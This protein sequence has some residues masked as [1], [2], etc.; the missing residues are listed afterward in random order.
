[1]T[2]HNSKRIALI[3]PGAMGSALAARLAEAGHDVLTSLAGRSAASHARA[4]AAGMA[5]ATDA[6]LAECDMILSVVPPAEADALVER[7]VPLLRDRS[8]KPLFVDANALNPASKKRL[9]ARLAEIGIDMV[10]GAIIGPPPVLGQRATT[11][12]LSGSQAGLAGPILDVPGCGATVLEGGVGAASA[13]KMCFGGINKGVVGLA[14]ALLLAAD[15]HGAAD[16]LRA[17]MQRSMPDLFLRYGRQIPD[18][19]PKAYRWVAEMEEIA[20]F[21]AEDDPSG[22]RLFEG[23]AGL[24]AAVEDDRQGGGE[25][26]DILK[27]AVKPD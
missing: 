17:E 2:D 1:M 21:L 8:I 9:A 3:S 24:F 6:E 11:T 12:F 18:M 14:T 7:F 25:A 16:A 22:A 4:T 20:A 23:M 10:D 15:R 5:D 27:R 26:I 13:L 19:V